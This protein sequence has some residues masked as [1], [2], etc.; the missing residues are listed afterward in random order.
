MTLIDSAS[1]LI[2]PT[3]RARLDNISDQQI[4]C[5]SCNSTYPVFKGRPILLSNDNILFQK[6]DYVDARPKDY[7]RT[8]LSS[9]FPK[10]TADLSVRRM[11]TALARRLDERGPSI[12]VIVGGGCQREWLTPIICANVVHEV[13]YTDIDTAADVDLFCDAHNLPFDSGSVD[14]VITTA[15]LEHVMYPERAAAEISRILK[16]GGLLYSEIPFMQQVHE[17]AYDFTR[18]TLS[19]HRRLFNSFSEIEAGMTAGPGSALAWSIESYARAFFRSATMRQIVTGLCRIFS[20]LLK[21]TDRFSMKN[22]AA[23]DGAC[24]TFFYGQKSDVLRSDE[25]I[26]SAYI[27]GRH[28]SHS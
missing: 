26:V 23:M 28:L 14:A 8:S 12:V 11:V 10:I 6:D 13:I 2:C 9:Y 20:G 7:K 4:A 27:G 21:Y 16:T 17:G 24:G 15:V 18:Y 3:C 22:P 19:G 1:K 5:N 25:D